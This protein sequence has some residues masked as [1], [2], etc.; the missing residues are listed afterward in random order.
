MTGDGFV[1]ASVSSGGGAP[2]HL[3]DEEGQLQRLL[4]VQPG[5]ARGVVPGGEL[6]VGDHL[7]TAEALSNRFA[8]V[9]NVNT[10]RMRTDP[11][12]DLEETLDLVHDAVETPRLVTAR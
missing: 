5:V 10:T 4:G 8:C 2:Q 1:A 12:M 3:D 6:A 9:L 7:R 11:T